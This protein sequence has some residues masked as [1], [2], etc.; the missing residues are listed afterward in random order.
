MKIAVT[1]ASGR[2]GQGIVQLAAARGHKLVM[3]DRV[4]PPVPPPAGASFIAVEMADYEGLV[5]AFSGCDALVHMAA[6]PV[7]D[8]LPD[9][10]V[11]NNNVVGSYNAL[12]AA[13]ENGITRICQAS[14]VNAIGHSFSRA[15][16]YDYFPLDEDHPNYCEDPYSLSKWLCEEQGLAFARRYP[17]LSIA[18]LRFHLVVPT[19]E[20]AVQYHAGAPD[21]AKHLWAWTQLEAAADACLLSLTADFSG[22]VAFYV[23]AP[24]TLS[25]IPTETLASRHFPQVPLTS[26]LID[27]QSFFSSSKAA[28]L[29]GW[30][31]P[32]L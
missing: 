30:R 23:V 18:S 9:H 1:G 8:I 19:R 10:I 7:P 6:I 31:H 26:P 11:H 28:R 15:P 12:R 20:A 24:E 4:P 14:S 13:V 5:A 25:D 27:R 16:R 32:S 22:H 17:A 29:L 3:I 2:V 21:P